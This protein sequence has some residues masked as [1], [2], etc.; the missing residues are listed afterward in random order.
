MG[1]TVLVYG[2]A[3]ATDR[4]PF[5]PYDIFARELTIKGSF[6]QTHCFDRALLAL[7]TG[8]VRTDGIVT[9]VVPLEK[10]DQALA[11]VGSSASVKAVVTP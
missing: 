3:D 8:R 10:F 6:A 11:A 1:G 2:M 4:V 9:D 5:S 7:R